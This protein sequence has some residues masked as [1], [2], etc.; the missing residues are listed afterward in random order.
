MRSFILTP[1]LLMV[2]AFVLLFVTLHVAALRNE[3]CVSARAHCV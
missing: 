3:I 1:L 2:L